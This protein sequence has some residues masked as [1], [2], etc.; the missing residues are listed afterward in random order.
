VEKW[1]ILDGPTQQMVD[2]HD[3]FEVWVATLQRTNDPKQTRSIRVE[4]SR[5]VRH[6]NPHLAAIQTALRTNG[7]TAIERYL[8][9]Q[10]PP[11]RL[12]VG[13]TTILA[14]DY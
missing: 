11:A 12:Y 2:V 3:D 8:D 5:S 1:R 14:S 6:S 9:K 13:G 4:I 7:R 10:H